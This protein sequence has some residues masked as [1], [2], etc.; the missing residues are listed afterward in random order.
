MNL[1]IECETSNTFNELRGK[2]FN[3]FDINLQ[4]EKGISILMY[5]CKFQKDV[6]F[7]KT[8]LEMK[9]D[10]NLQDND[11]YTALIYAC[12]YPEICNYF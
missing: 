11:G 9:P 8:L 12:Q 1:E 10:I 6:S 3:Y 5:A 7:F 2:L 4:D